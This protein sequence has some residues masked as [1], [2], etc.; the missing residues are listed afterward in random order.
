MRTL[1]S[2]KY[3]RFRNNAG[4]MDILQFLRLEVYLAVEEDAESMDAAMD[5]LDI[6][7]LTNDISSGHEAC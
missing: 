4:S 6:G 5:I 7:L 2:N 3:G 1:M